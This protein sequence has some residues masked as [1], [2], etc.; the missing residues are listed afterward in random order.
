MLFRSSTDL[1]RI[2]GTSF[3]SPPRGSFSKLVPGVHK[4]NPSCSTHTISEA[5]I[6]HAASHTAPYIRHPATPTPVIPASFG[7]LVKVSGTPF[8]FQ[9]DQTRH[10]V[11]RLFYTAQLT[12]HENFTWIQTPCVPPPKLLRYRPKHHRHQHCCHHQHYLI[13]RQF[14]RQL[15]YRISRCHNQWYPTCPCVEIVD[16]HNSIPRNRC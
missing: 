7:T 8:R 14:F 3:W 13:F 5:A 10:I 4:T 15:P 2:L 9:K 1:C 6:A 11:F 16:H 12:P